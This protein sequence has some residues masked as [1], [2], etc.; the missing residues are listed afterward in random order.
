MERGSREGSCCESHRGAE[1]V[2]ARVLKP[3]ASRRDS[4]G[5]AMLEREKLNS[6]ELHWNDHV[7]NEIAPW[8]NQRL[9]KRPKC[10]RSRDSSPS[11][12]DSARPYSSCPRRP[13]A[14]VTPSRVIL[15]ASIS[16]S[17]ARPSFR[18]LGSIFNAKS[19]ML[20]LF[21]V[22]QF[23]RR[24]D[25]VRSRYESNLSPEC[26]LSRLN[27]SPISWQRTRS[28]ADLEA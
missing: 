7:S 8:P 10:N 3:R 5:S 27:S 12:V 15:D 1:L 4:K 11:L 13:S 19:T 18:Y 24:N 16:A 20:V 26:Y 2:N 14:S 17:R 23:R 25:D 9:Q 21:N 28:E 22:F 6:H